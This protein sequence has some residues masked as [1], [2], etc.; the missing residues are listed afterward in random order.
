MVIVKI[1]N[2]INNNDMNFCW[3]DGKGLGEGHVCASIG[4]TNQQQLLEF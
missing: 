2:N 4:L 3:S 1:N